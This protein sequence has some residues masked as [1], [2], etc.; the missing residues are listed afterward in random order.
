MHMSWVE[1]CASGANGVNFE[2]IRAKQCRNGVKEGALRRKYLY[3]RVL[4]SWG[5][6]VV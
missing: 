2:N 4:G 5:V 6:K 3:K 1:V